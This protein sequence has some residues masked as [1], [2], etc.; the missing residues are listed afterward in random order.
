MTRASDLSPIAAI[1]GQNGERLIALAGWIN[2]MPD[3]P[4]AHLLLHPLG[5]GVADKMQRLAGILGLEPAGPATPMPTV[6]PDTAYAT[7]DTDA[8]NAWLHYGT[9]AWMHRPV[10]EDW[11]S[12]ARTRRT[13]ALWLGLDGGTIRTT[14]DADKFMDRSARRERLYG[15]LVRVMDA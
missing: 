6:P 9:A 8:S 7:I 13:L 3:G 12:A 14:R 4:G 15:G 10:T 1:L 5:H 2:D 11:I